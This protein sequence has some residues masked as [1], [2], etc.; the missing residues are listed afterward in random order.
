MEVLDQI[1][2]INNQELKCDGYEE[3]ESIQDIDALVTRK[4]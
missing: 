2:G 1:V 4:W 3:G